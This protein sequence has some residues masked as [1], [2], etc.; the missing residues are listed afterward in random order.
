MAVVSSNGS[1]PEPVERRVSRRVLFESLEADTVPR[2]LVRWGVAGTAH[3]SPHASILLSC[4]VWWAFPDLIVPVS[5]ATVDLQLG[6]V[7]PK[8]L[9]VSDILLSFGA[10]SAH[11]EWYGMLRRLERQNSWLPQA[12]DGTPLVL[13]STMSSQPLPPVSTPKSPDPLSELGGNWHTL[14]SKA[15]RGLRILATYLY[16]ASLSLLQQLWTL[17]RLGTN[18]T[19]KV[20]G[21]WVQGTPVEAMVA[22]G[23]QQVVSVAQLCMSALEPTWRHTSLVAAWTK[24]RLSF[25]LLLATSAGSGGMRSS[26]SLSRAAGS[27]TSLGVATTVPSVLLQEYWVAVIARGGPALQRLRPHLWPQVYAESHSKNH[28]G[29]YVY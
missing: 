4:A 11:S 10:T 3:L 26:S 16:S 18:A 9:H 1:A 23:A 17:A 15:G 14:L 5:V 21:R 27:L 2:M 13:Q 29:S 24:D 19:S 22:A 7:T 20:V 25:A 6:Y 12:D 8:L 28:M